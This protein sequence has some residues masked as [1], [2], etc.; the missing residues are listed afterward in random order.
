M[1]PKSTQN[2]TGG[3]GG[4][5]GGGGKNKT[6]NKNTKKKKNG[7]TNLPQKNDKNKGQKKPT[8]ETTLNKQKKYKRPIK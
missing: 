3:V 7:W 4:G 6:Q 2:K 5:G 1:N 8:Q